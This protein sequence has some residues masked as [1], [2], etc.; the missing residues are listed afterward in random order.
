[1][2]ERRQRLAGVDQ[3]APQIESRLRIGRIDLR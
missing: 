3:R 2:R 1:V